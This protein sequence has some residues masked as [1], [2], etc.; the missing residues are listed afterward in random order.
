MV[1]RLRAQGIR[2]PR[3]LAALRSVP[4]HILVPEALR[5][6]AYEESAL[7]IGE[8]Q[9]ISAPGVVAAM[10]EALALRGHEKVLEIGTGSAY[11]SAIL[12]HLADRVISVERIPSLA[13]DARSALDACGVTNVVVFL[14]DG[15]RGWP[16]EAPYD[17][18]VV[19]AAAPSVPEPLLRQ[20]APGGRLVGPFG[21]R[22]EQAL[23]RITRQ[24]DGQLLREKLG[25]CRFVDLVG[26]HG[27]A[28]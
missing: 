28:A 17:A 20:L 1:A 7:P 14:G 10:S 11:Q 6:R 24:P 13:N 23:L 5:H 25:S 18:I 9:T 27:W 21:E 8:G 26:E 2:D 12:S 19:T 22:E 4:R 16:A 3:V 15:T